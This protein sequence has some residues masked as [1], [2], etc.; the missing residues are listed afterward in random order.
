MIKTK[1]L[2][3]DN[4]SIDEREK[5]LYTMSFDPG[6]PHVLL[7]TCNRTELYWGEGQISPDIALHLFRV[8]AGLES[9]LIGER[10]IQG[11]I[12]TA[13][14]AATEQY[15]LS[16]SLNRLFQS[17]MHVGKRVRIETQIA[18]GA[19]S[20]SQVTA[21]ML[22]KHNIDLKNKII[23]IIGVNK[24]TEDILKFLTARGAVNIYLSNRNFDRCAALAAQYG[25]TAMSLD[26]KRDLLGIADVLICAT[27]A[28]HALVHVDDFPQQR[29]QHMLLF[30]LA[31]PR[32]I[33]P[34]VAQMEGI[35]LYNLEDIET[36]GR[37][38]ISLRQG[39]IAKAEHIID[40]EIAK[41]LDWQQKKAAHCTLNLR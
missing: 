27:S 38:N 25:G 14:A 7:S 23:A 16:A 18:T 36:F 24:L 30:D 4:H 15:R 41:L 17:A 35:T 33:D 2:N 22:R 39:Q 5:L 9:A 29:N 31:F 20:H 40:D 8:A 6:T 37:Q 10:A 34:E 13:Y 26:N 21:D 12:K 1:L 19:V 28:P 11:Q 32:D 3:R